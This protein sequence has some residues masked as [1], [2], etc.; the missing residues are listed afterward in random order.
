MKNSVIISLLSAQVGADLFLDIYKGKSTP[1]Y[2]Y[3]INIVFP[4]LRKKGRF[5]LFFPLREKIGKTPICVIF[6]GRKIS[7][8]FP[9]EGKKISE[10]FPLLL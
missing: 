4:S 7:E 1:L 3:E 9:F 6:D 10:D 8:F 5:F 2:I